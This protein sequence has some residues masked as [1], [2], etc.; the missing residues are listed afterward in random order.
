MCAQILSRNIPIN[1]RQAH[2][3][4]LALTTA[5]GSLLAEFDWDWFATLTF[6]YATSSHRALEIY[7]GFIDDIEKVASSPLRWFAVE[8]YG[9]FDRLHF[10]C[11]IAGTSRLDRHSWQNDW[12]KRA[13]HA[14]ILEYIRG[15]GAAH[16]CAKHLGHD[17]VEYY[18]SD[19]LLNTAT[20]GDAPGPFG[21]IT[22]LST[23]AVANSDSMGKGVWDEIATKVLIRNDELTNIQLSEVDSM[24]S[25]GN[26]TDMPKCHN[27]R[28]AAAN[29]NL[30][31]IGR[32]G[33]GETVREHE[34]IA[35]ALAQE[36]QKLDKQLREKIC[37]TKK[38]TLE[39]GRLLRQI[40]EKELHKYLR[41]PGSRKGYVQF[42]DYA[43]EVTGLSGSSIW[44][45]M[46]VFGLTEG[47]N[48]VP[49]RD[50][51]EM[52]IVNAY[53]LTKIPAD[54]RTPA[55]VEEAKCYPVQKFRIKIQEVQN[56]VLP[57][58]ERR[59]VLIDFYRKLHPETA[60][61]L[62]DTIE[63]FCL[64]QVVRDCSRDKTLQ[65]KAIETL[66][67]AALGFAGPEIR[68]ERERLARESFEIREAIEN[69]TE[70]MAEGTRASAS[71]ERRAASR[72]SK[73]PQTRIVAQGVH[74]IYS[75]SVSK[76]V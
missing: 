4:T 10:H 13:G 60:Q 35:L 75:S 25:T 30:P 38:L 49:S 55:L 76:E 6:R 29:S 19:S 16:Y 74:R 28:E 8:E 18:F 66:C 53:E 33:P 21:N 57:P 68:A 11:L 34:K 36:A 63:D 65:E 51:E 1:A 71:A 69:T 7:R 39:I 58:E 22:P 50:I 54:K 15:R 64:L 48:P 42:S 62:E 44:M 26:D 41:Q 3:R 40:R 52:P 2:P 47:L 32:I 61:M 23:G 67:T 43:A 9:T 31:N 70:T 14:V 37:A 12:F 5:W 20:G 24:G 27:I 17:S 73:L 45:A 72:P 46:K 59:P 56:E